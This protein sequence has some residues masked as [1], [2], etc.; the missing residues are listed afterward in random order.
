MKIKALRNMPGIKAGEEFEIRELELMEGK[1][2]RMGDVIFD[3]GTLRAYVYAG[4]W[5]E[6]VRNELLEKFKERIEE[7]TI[8]PWEQLT[9]ISNEHYKEKVSAA[10]EK[11]VRSV[12][13]WKDLKAKVMEV[14]K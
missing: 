10:F 14:F 4:Y 8:T 7:H 11:G 1:Q 12:S 2:I 6:K 3:R 9:E 13:S 5:F